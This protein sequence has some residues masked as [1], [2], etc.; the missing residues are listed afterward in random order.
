MLAAV[1]GWCGR[2]AAAVAVL[3]LLAGLGGVL[4]VQARLG[5]STDT[6]RLFSA[7]LPWKQRQAELQAAFPQGEDLLAVVVD[8]TIPEAADATAASLAEALTGDPHF[9]A[10][11][12]PD[13]SPWFTR[14]ALLFVPPDKLQPLLDQTIDAQP[15]LGQLAA[16]PSL[17]G[18]AAA[19]GLIAEGV[20]RGQ[21][22]LAG[23]APALRGFHTA[24]AAAA[25]GHPA[26][27]SWE[28]LLAGPLAAL[29]GQYR[30][31]LAKPVLDYGALQPGA[32]AT[33]AIRAAASRLEF[34]RDGTARVRITGSVAL[35]DD[36][37][38][39]VAA[40][41]AG[42]LLAS[43]VLVTLWLFL[44]V[45]S[46][47]LIVPIVLTLLLGLDLTAAFAAAAVGTLNLVSVA[48]AV[49]FVGL[50]VDFAIQF[51]VRF[52]EARL[53][54]DR[55]AGLDHDAVVGA[56][57]ATAGGAGAQILVAA[58]ATAAGFLAFAPTSFAGVAQ[59]GII[60]GVGMLIAFCCTLT[61]L[62]A[63][64]KLFRP[65]PEAAEVGLRWARPVD[66]WIVRRHRAVLGG[67]AAAA[68]LGLA[69]L[70]WLGFDS[71]PLHTK[72]QATESVRTLDDLV[73]DPITNPY[74]IDI[75]APSAAAAAAL[76]PRLRTLPTVDDVLT[77]DSLVPDDQAAKLA[78]LQDAAGLLQASLSPDATAAAPG[79]AVM[80][81]AVRHAAARLAAVRDKLPEGDPLAAIAGDLA[82]LGEAS[83][84][85]L[86]AADRALTRF[87]PLQL[88]RLRVA[89]AAGPVSRDDVPPDVKRDWVTPDGR[90]KLQ[91]LPRHAVATAG[92]A[93]L[94]RFVAEVSA[95]APDAGGAA[96]TIVRSADT[97]IGAFRAAA[98]SAVVC[99]AAI[100]L[101]SLRRL[102]DA[103]LVLAPL[104][105][106][107]LLTVALTVALGLPLNFANIIALP[108]LLGVGV[109]F[110]VYFIMNW[111]AGRTHPLSSAT[112][113][114]VLLSALTTATAFGSL[115]VSSHP[116][117]ASMGRLLLLSLACT[118][119]TTFLFV[120]AA[121]AALPRPPQR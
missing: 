82:A 9:S 121:L 44:A 105:L 96:V 79:P 6:G 34:V 24:L 68:V 1:A 29:A 49:L 74:S 63:L 40:G 115:A 56:L 19:L 53:G 20:E 42:G 43:L 47:R 65:A 75:L 116:G 111:R 112:A 80:R 76:A 90:A 61:A 73:Q 33:A 13:A 106:S 8:A 83:D 55:E 50:A 25:A 62:P 15:F 26:P 39:S 51:A 7:S 87:L 32:A 5:V 119:L 102:L 100:L 113:R 57:A 36:E 118:L 71:D 17:R 92:N 59:L 54:R 120:P 67:S 31:V 64:L 37:F 84:P 4:L 11:S 94:H 86:L 60:A 98:L 10:V 104:L 89:L 103:G 23:F 95:V 107:S 52:R 93:G 46:W 108:L 110:N 70:P 101:L 72:N 35:D 66:G 109:S 2:R 18:L 99:I 28:T 12:R 114:A 38:A 97:I 78:M 88:D 21:A 45:R 27:L 117:T 30:F 3:A 77:L 91:V 22:D 41:A 69:L 81:E 16:D 58:L 85:V 48:F 14:N